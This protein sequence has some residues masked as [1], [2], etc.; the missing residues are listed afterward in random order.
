VKSREEREALG[1]PGDGM[2][3]VRGARPKGLSI[4]DGKASSRRTG[5]GGIGELKREAFGSNPFHALRVDTYREVIGLSAMF[6]LLS[7]A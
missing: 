5:C 2:S 1:V 7:A 6:L 4:T 3:P